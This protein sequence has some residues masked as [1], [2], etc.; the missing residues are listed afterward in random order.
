MRFI[1]FDFYFSVLNQQPP[2][3]SLTPRQCHVCDANF[4]HFSSGCSLYFFVSILV[5]VTHKLPRLGAHPSRELWLEL[6]PPL[7]EAQ[8]KF[9][10]VNLLSIYLHVCFLYILSHFFFTH[11]HLHLC[12]FLWVHVSCIPTYFL[13]CIF[14][15]A[16]P[17][18]PCGYPSMCACAEVYTSFLV[19][20]LA[21]SERP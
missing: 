2:S 6:F 3:T 11:N 10:T 15:H 7:R 4:V 1:P 21:S 5:R 13:I 17:T 16:C 18:H 20:A 9:I 19:I 8:S 14:M 12:A